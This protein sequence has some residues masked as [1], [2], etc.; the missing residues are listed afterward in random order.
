MDGVTSTVT[1]FIEVQADDPSFQYPRGF[2][3]LPHMEEHF[4]SARNASGASVLAYVPLIQPDALELWANYSFEN[5]GWI[6]RYNAFHNDDGLVDPILK[7]IWDYSEDDEF[8]AYLKDECEYK[9]RS[10]MTQDFDTA[11]DELRIPLKPQDR[12]FSP[13]WTFSPAPKPSDTTIINHDL[14]SRDAFKAAVQTVDST[15]KPLFLD[16]CNLANWFNVIGTSSNSVEA[17]V[18]YPVFEDFSG[19]GNIVGHMIEILPWA[20]FFKNILP[21][22]TEPVKVVLESS[23]GRASAYEIRGRQIKLLNPNQD[24]HNEEYNAMAVSSIFADFA[25]SPEV[26]GEGLEGVCIYTVSVYPTAEF[27]SAYESQKP[28]HYAL[29][30]LSV[31]VCTSMLFFLFDFLMTRQR[32]RVMDTAK[33]QNAIVS[34]LFPKNIQAKMMQDL[35]NNKLSKI[36]KAGLK[37]YLFDTQTPSR[38]DVNNTEASAIGGFSDKSKPIA[39]LFPETTIMFGDIAG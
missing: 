22:G 4:G 16:V 2:L 17:V 35:E 8:H 34:S 5:Q 28:V 6:A 27:E 15:R 30:V 38:N 33:K 25:N 21:E 3:T 39:D 36:G 31:F 23:C 26:I 37:S 9:E 18:A 29:V 19:H 20:Y 24:L 12:P 7:D 1:S 32:N 13:I 10:E 11:N 14:F